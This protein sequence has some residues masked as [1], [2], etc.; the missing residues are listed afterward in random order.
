MK[1]IIS[2]FIIIATFVMNV[3]AATSV[4]TTDS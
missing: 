3:S 1:H 2:L 4:E